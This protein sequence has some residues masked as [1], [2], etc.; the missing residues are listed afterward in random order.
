[1]KIRN[2]AIAALALMLPLAAVACSD[3]STGDLS[4]GEMTSQLQK[5]GMTKTQAECAAKILKKAD[6][7]KDELNGFTDSK[8]TNSKAGKVIMQAVTECLTPTTSGS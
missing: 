2:L 5:S 8:D 3:D 1:M 7:T 6:L 4:I